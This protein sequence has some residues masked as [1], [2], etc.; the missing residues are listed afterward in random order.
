MAQKKKRRSRITSESMCVRCPYFKG[1]TAKSVFCE[2][3]ESGSRIELSF[4]TEKQRHLYAS[5]YCTENYRLCM[6]ARMNDLK[7][8][9]EGNL[10]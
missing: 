6:I 10:I 4:R 8:D 9:E 1:Q 2:G 7:Y 5:K 3:V